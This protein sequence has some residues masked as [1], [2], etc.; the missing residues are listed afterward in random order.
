MLSW[1]FKPSQPQKIILGLKEI[2]IRKYIVEKISKAEIRPEELS[3]KAES[4][5][6]NLWNEM[7][8][9]GPYRQKQTQER[10]KKEWASSVGLGQNIVHNIPST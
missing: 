3:E 6:E 10:D 9:K 1:C 5:R 8:L 4:C 2:F 7:Q